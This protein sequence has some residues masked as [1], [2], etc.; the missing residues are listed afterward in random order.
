MH[1]GSGYAVMTGRLNA[2]GKAVAEA[3]MTY[4]LV[5]FPREVLR[6]RMLEAARRVGVPEEF[7]RGA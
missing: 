6:T 2:A 1:D 5:P 7:F 3:E 4:R